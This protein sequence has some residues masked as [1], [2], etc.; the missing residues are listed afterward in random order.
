MPGSY[1]CWYARHRLLEAGLTPDRGAEPPPAASGHPRFRARLGHVHRAP[2]Y[3]AESDLTFDEVKVEDYAAVLVLGG[4]APEYLRHDP[5]V[6]SLV[7]AFD[8]AGKWVFAICH[9]VRSSQRPE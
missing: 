3:G 2:G 6:L 7:R 4:R 1:E 9:G 8:K 5:R